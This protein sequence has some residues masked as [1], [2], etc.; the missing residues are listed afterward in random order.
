[1]A[2]GPVRAGGIPGWAVCCFIERNFEFSRFPVS[3]V[4][5]A[6]GQVARAFLVWGNICIADGLGELR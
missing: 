6:V 5:M 4:A 1:M 3:G 2:V